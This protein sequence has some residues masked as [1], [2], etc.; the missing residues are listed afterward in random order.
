VR[1]ALEPQVVRRISEVVTHPHADDPQVDVGV[2]D[3]VWPAPTRDRMPCLLDMPEPEVLAYSPDSV[4]TEK[5]EAIVVLGDR[6]SRI[7]DFFDIRYLA[8]HHDFHRLTLA[9][10]IRRTFARRKT[11]VPP[12]DPFGLTKDYWDS[13]GRSAQVRAFARRAGI[14]VGPGDLSTI[15]S[16][17]RAFLLPVLDDVR[18][19]HRTE[20]TWTP[21]GPWR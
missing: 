10:A 8:E 6:N 19:S 15:P 18:R 20:G 4:V 12:D 11:P 13:P 14:E 5:L 7:K 1:C 21:P 2:G 3:A 17:L 9:E 16:V